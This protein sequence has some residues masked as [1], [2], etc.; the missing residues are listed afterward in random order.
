MSRNKILAIL[1]L[2]LTCLFFFG[3]YLMLEID[4]SWTYF[5]STSWT[6]LLFFLLDA[7]MYLILL[8][9]NIRNDDYAY[10]GIA[11]FVSMETFGFL[12]KLLYGQMA[13]LSALASGSPIAY[14]LQ[15][16]YVSFW[17]MEAGV[18]IALYIF[19]TRYRRGSPNFLLVRIFAILFAAFLTLTTVVS[20]VSIFWSAPFS[21]K[22]LLSF[23]ALPLSE[24]CAGVG[25][26]FTLER[27]KRS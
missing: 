13:S 9:C 17:A 20:S 12:Q 27:L 8:T 7:V 16:L 10:V 2:S 5:R 4:C 11:L 25:I 15:S 26:V 21:W 3:Y 19:I 1:F 14:L 24:A 23:A 22:L 6:N 18:G